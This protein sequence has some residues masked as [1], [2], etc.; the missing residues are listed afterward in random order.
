MGPLQTK[1]LRVLESRAFRRIGA[2][3]EQPLRARVVAATHHDLADLVAQGRFR[4]D[5]YQRLCVFP[6]HLPPLR[7]RGEDV[8]RLAEHFRQFFCTRLGKTIEPLGGEVGER[9]LAYPFPGN[10]RELKN[11]MER[12]V[13]VCDAARIEL[14]HLPARVLADDRPPAVPGLPLEFVPGADSLESLERRLI[15]QALQQAGGVK[16]EAARRLGLSRFQLLRRLEKYG[17][18]GEDE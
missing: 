3:R 10:V 8:L 6:I 4:Q 11:V 9:L 7:E 15:V 2:L 18:R 16:A 17:L 14:G 12:A 5:L 13:I 1:L